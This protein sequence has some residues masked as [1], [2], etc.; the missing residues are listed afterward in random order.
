MI[1]P[2]A[3][4]IKAKAALPHTTGTLAGE[5]CHGMWQSHRER[6]HTFG[7][8]TCNVPEKPAGTGLSLEARKTSGGLPLN[9]QFSSTLLYTAVTHRKH[10]E[11][12][13][14]M[15]TP[16]GTAG[17]WADR[18][19]CLGTGR[20]SLTEQT[21]LGPCFWIRK[22]LLSCAGEA[23]RRDKEAPG[24]TGQSNLK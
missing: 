4:L 12:C 7:A 22:Q 10:G 3:D 20:E 8:E 13:T 15:H 21:L 6:T 17:K 18:L 14:G 19:L 16:G 1:H 2:A 5:L 23:L 9:T 24:D 11:T